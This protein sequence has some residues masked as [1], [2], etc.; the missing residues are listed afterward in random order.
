MYYAHAARVASKYRYEG[1]DS[2]QLNKHIS[3]VA[4]LIAEDI[5]TLKQD[6]KEPRKWHQQVN[7][8]SVCTWLIGFFDSLLFWEEQSGSKQFCEILSPSHK[9]SIGKLFQKFSEE[10][11]RDAIAAVVLPSQPGN[12]SRV[13]LPSFQHPRSNRLCSD[14]LLMKALKKPKVSIREMELTIPSTTDQ[15]EAGTGRRSKRARRS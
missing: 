14:T 15:A 13:G 11:R 3:S 6:T 9:F 12:E 7:A 5:L 4:M 2:M 8:I 10:I 1:V